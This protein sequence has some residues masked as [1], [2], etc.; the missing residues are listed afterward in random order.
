MVALVKRRG[1]PVPAAFVGGSFVTDELSPGDIDAA[2]IID[3]SAVTKPATWGIV[4]R[5]LANAKTRGLQVDAFAIPWFPDG[6]EF[7]GASPAYQFERGKWDDFWQ[8]KV[9]KADRVPPVRE[10][11]MPTRGY[12][13]VILDGYA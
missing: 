10:H 7:G 5:L 1:V 4:Q 9:A 12:L 8:R 2:L 11:A 6:S 13:E 3:V